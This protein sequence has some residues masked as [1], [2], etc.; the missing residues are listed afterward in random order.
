MMI[1]DNARAMRDMNER[2]YDMACVSILLYI[3][4]YKHTLM[5]SPEARACAC[6]MALI[7]YTEVCSLSVY[8]LTVC[9]AMCVHMLL[10]LS[11][12]L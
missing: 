2:V 10:S 5:F 12:Y 11:F 8:C 4:I 6:S 7:L 1:R 9:S 3:Y